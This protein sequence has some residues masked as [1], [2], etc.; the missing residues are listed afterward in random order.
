[1]G[2]RGASEEREGG[3]AGSIVER[4]KALFTSWLVPSFPPFL[5][6]EF[7]ILLEAIF[8]PKKTGESRMALARP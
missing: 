1:M 3:V 5:L 8:R 7:W 6:L 4:L 2:W